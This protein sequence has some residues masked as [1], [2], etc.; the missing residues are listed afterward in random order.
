MSVVLWSFSFLEEHLQKCL[1][2][3]HP[4]RF[5]NGTWITVGTMNEG[6]NVSCQYIEYDDEAAFGCKQTWQVMCTNSHTDS[7]D[8][9]TCENGVEWLHEACVTSC[10][11]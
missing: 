4:A 6:F 7:T 2:S 8:I 5:N 9:W 3:L 1:H 11:T 10:F